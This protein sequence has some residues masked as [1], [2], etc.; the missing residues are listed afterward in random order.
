MMTADFPM[1]KLNEYTHQFSVKVTSCT[2]AMCVYIYVDIQ[3]YTHTYIELYIRYLEGESETTQH[4]D[5][6]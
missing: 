6:E 5:L 3:R 2:I 1:S 4:G